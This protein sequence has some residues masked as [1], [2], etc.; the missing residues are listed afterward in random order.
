MKAW[1]LNTGVLWTK[2]GNK[3][4]QGTRSESTESQ[5]TTSKDR[6]C[7]APHTDSGVWKNE[8]DKIHRQALK[9][10]SNWNPPGAGIL[11]AGAVPT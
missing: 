7:T 6:L 10:I 5:E 3:R 11:P 2:V 9:A 4:T 1:I 8:K